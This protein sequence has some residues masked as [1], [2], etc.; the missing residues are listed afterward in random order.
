M[1]QLFALLL[2]LAAVVA[3]FGIGRELRLIRRHLMGLP[4]PVARTRREV[5]TGAIKPRA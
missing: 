5:M 4:A 2:A 3:L 1:L